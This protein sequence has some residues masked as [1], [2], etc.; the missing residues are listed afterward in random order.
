MPLRAKRK[1]GQDS[2]LTSEAVWDIRRRLMTVSVVLKR[3][4]EAPSQP[5]KREKHG[6]EING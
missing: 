2:P 3:M 1:E 5:A 4:E 6:T